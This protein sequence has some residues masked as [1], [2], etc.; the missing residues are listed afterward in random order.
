MA[1]FC[2]QC[3][4]PIPDD[5]SFCTS[6]GT[7]VQQDSAPGQA[8]QPVYNQPGNAPYASTFT[9]QAPAKSKRGP[10]I[11]IVCSAVGVVVIL[12]VVLLI[13]FRRSDDGETTSEP[14][15]ESSSSSV[16][17]VAPAVVPGQDPQFSCL[18]GL[19]LTFDQLADEGY[20]T[21]D[22]VEGGQL[23]TFNR[24]GDEAQFLMAT[25]G[26]SGESLPVALRTTLEKVFPD[27]A[28]LTAKEAEAKYIP[29]LKVSYS[30]GGSAEGTYETDH[31]MCTIYPDTSGTLRGEDVVEIRKKGVPVASAVSSEAPEVSSSEA[32]AQPSAPAETDESNYY[33]LPQSSQRLLTYVDIENFTK[34]DMMLA[35]NEIFARH[36]RKFNDEDIRTYFE[37]QS[38]YN[39]TIAPED[40]S[41]SVLSAVEQQNIDFI[42]QYED[43][44]NGVSQQVGSS[45]SVITYNGYMI[46]QSSSR[47][48]TYADIAGLSKWQLS[49]ARN[50]IY[51]RN[52]RMFSD[53][54]IRAYFEAQSWY[55]GYIAPENFTTSMLSATEQYNVEFIKSYE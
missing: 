47:R 19:D 24:F 26:L 51:A 7:P 35:R 41:T 42:K 37:A 27:L 44:L 39:G 21:G 9:Q 6:C 48:L 5:S 55:Y 40:F 14:V 54:D 29:Y 45:G 30:T 10:V 50:E 52:G 4:A 15:S 25:E 31:Y 22:E 17:A 43:G 11:A 3:G 12:A 13:L 32:P 8:Q 33:I 38:W 20:F 23:Y 28:G 49:I 53:P 16:E 46:P 1:K 36:G 34:Q 18:R 2:T